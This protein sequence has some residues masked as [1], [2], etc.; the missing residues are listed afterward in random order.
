M[1]R[2][3]SDTFVNYFS[4]YRNDSNAG[5]KRSANL[6]M[7]R[8]L[9]DT[10]KFSRCPIPDL[11]V[12]L[13]QINK[14]DST[15]LFN[16]IKDGV[17]YDYPIVVALKKYNPEINNSSWAPTATGFS[18]NVGHAL[19]IVG[20]VERADVEDS[21]VLIRDVYLE[22]PVDNSWS[23]LFDYMMSV[24]DL[25]DNLQASNNKYDLILFKTKQNGDLKELALQD[26][27]AETYSDYLSDN[28]RS[29]QPDGSYFYSN[30]AGYHSSTLTGPQ[31]ADFDLYLYKWNSGWEIVRSST[32]GSSNESIE[33][34]GSSGYYIWMV[35]S[36][37]GSGN[38][39]V[40]I[41]KP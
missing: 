35:K 14:G 28:E 23:Q 25:M 15:A 6:G 40:T 27:N 2:P 31:N 10:E 36:Y 3:Q 26:A 19:V 39:K 17:N 13:R 24:E 38:F 32:S 8:M 1:V 34:N 21:L 33:Y 12:V 22:E 20:Y 30:K 5:G 11:N 7:F 9:G 29:F 37:S 41:S 4:A 16:K 18:G